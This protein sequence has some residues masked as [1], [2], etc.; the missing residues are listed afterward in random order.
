[1]W[2]QGYSKTSK[3]FSISI[4]QA[5]TPLQHDIVW[6]NFIIIEGPNDSSV[7]EIY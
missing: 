7:G 1:M 3:L 5:L 6:V 4:L 2:K